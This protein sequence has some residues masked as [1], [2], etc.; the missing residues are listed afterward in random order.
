MTPVVRVKGGVEFDRIAPAG[1]VLLAAIQSLPLILGKD[2]WITSGTDSHVNADPHALG[3][4]Y[5]L[6]VSGLTAHD[7]LEV[8]NVFAMMGPQFYAQYEVPLG[9]K[10]DVSLVGVAV[11]NSRATGPHIHCQRSKGTSYPQPDT[12]RKA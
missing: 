3:E 2:I 4:A 12:V 5:D 7:I 9:Y 11:P 6:G 10:V 1:F 8:L